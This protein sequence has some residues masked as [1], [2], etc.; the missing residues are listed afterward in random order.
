MR[1]II[2]ERIKAEF[3]T[4]DGLIIISN[5]PVTSERYSKGVDA[6]ASYTKNTL[7]ALREAYPQK[8][9]I[10]LAPC[11]A[12]D[13]RFGYSID[14]G[15]LV[16][17]TFQR[18]NIPSLVSLA[19]EI[20]QFKNVPSILFEFEFSSFGDTK[21]TVFLPILLVIFRLLGKNTTVVLHQVV[22]DLATLSEHI[23]VKRNSAILKPMNLV[24]KQFY[25]TICFVAQ[26]VIV[27]EDE[28]KKRLIS[29]HIPEK[30]IHIVY[31]GIDKKLG[32]SSATYLNSRTLLQIQTNELVLLYFGY[33]TWYK[34]ADML[35]KALS[36]TTTLAGKKIKLI[37]AGGP[38][39]NQMNK[40]HYR[41]YYDK[42]KKTINKYKHIQLT[43]FLNERDIA[44]YIS[45]CDLTI[46]P[47]RT[48]MSSSGAFATVCA[49]EKPFILSNKLKN[50][51][52]SN[53]FQTIIRELGIDSN[54][55]MFPLRSDALQETI[56]KT[57]DEKQY[58]KMVLL[59][60]RLKKSRD[61]R[62]TAKT[63]LQILESHQK[64]G[65]LSSKQR[66]FS[67][68]YRSGNRLSFYFE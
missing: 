9:I 57:L 65:S 24:L 35:V 29:L 61:F 33:V 20:H 43:G 64:N 22:L 1:I 11:V 28:M 55:F 41:R 30:K 5:Y 3:D 21:V 50:Y 63:Y 6:T 36:Y 18:N 42:I 7:L 25:R 47:Y 10:V 19:R 68:T 23:G 34:G 53:D 27:L 14:E 45:A 8:K 16:A 37:I 62:N 54:L 31:H 46:F 4:H 2:P 44:L 52:A 58:Q 38:S 56:V 17:R 39:A 12:G 60:K 40:T 15:I 59:S 13:D 48:F 32:Q 26:S 66:S 67:D 49:F 51:I